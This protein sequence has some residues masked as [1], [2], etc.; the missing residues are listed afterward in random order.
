MFEYTKKRYKNLEFNSGGGG[1]L[2]FKKIRKHI[3]YVIIERTD[4]MSEK[5]SITIDYHIIINILKNEVKLKKRQIVSN[6]LPV[7]KISKF[8]QKIFR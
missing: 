8:L 6:T 1:Q 7:S 2:S 4:S 3:Y 5:Y